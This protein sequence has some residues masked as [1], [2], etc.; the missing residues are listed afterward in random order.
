MCNKLKKLDDTLNNHE[1]QLTSF[2][3]FSQIYAQKYSALK[4]EYE[5]K[6]LLLEK[7][8]ADY[9]QRCESHFKKLEIENQNM[10]AHIMQLTRKI[11]II[12]SKRK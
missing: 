6:V 8:I 10:L 5:Q 3:T 12:N 9:N 2:T 4:F 1:S 11:E 7:S